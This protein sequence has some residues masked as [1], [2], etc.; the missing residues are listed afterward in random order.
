[1]LLL[2]FCQRS[3]LSIAFVRYCPA[4]ST[5]SI[6]V[7]RPKEN[8]IVEYACSSDSPIAV[9]TWEGAIFPVVQAE[10]RLAAKSGQFAR[11][12]SARKPGNRMLLQ[13]GSRFLR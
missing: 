1:M 8:L 10:P 4:V 13:L 7:L 6:V 12:S 2:Q 3:S 11:I 5:S 9:S